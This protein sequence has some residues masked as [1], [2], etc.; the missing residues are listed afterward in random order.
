MSISKRRDKI[1]EIIKTTEVNTQ[2]ELVN[3]LRENGFLVTQATVSRDVKELGLV[4]VK[5]KIL[6]YRYAEPL[7]PEG[8]KIDGKI[9]PLFDAFIRSVVCAKNLVVVK[10]LEGH[11]SAC[12]MAVD[13]LSIA[14]IVGSVAGD[15]TLLIVTNSDEDAK[16]VETVIKGYVNL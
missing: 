14:E 9:T 3:I 4:K 2:D 15:D 6:K 5:G 13:K 11:A 8:Y 12:G 7:K 16:K 10:T 1:L